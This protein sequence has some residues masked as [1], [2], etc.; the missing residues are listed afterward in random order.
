[1][2]SI[3]YKTNKGRWLRYLISGVLVISGIVKFLDPIQLIE[4][5]KALGIKNVDILA[6]IGISVPLL[7]LSLG[8]AVFIGFKSKI[9]IPFT[10][11][12]FMSFLGISVYGYMIGLTNDCGCFGS[13]VKSKFGWLMITRNLLFF[14][15]SLYLLICMT[16]IPSRRGK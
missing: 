9:V 5:I 10:T 8:I 4:T 16:I 14:I 3:N 11:F 12:L 7:E 15:L 6:L 13:L 1:M 2:K